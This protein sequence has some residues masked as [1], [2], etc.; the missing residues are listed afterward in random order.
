MSLFSIGGDPAR[1][2]LLSKLWGGSR[3]L[4]HKSCLTVAFRALR[5]Y[6]HKL[7]FVFGF[8]LGWEVHF[9]F[10]CTIHYRTVLY[11]SLSSVVVPSAKR[12]GS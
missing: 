9:L 11:D 7:G 12:P 2:S 6:I 3:L 8:V 4:R 10:T 5:A 1:R